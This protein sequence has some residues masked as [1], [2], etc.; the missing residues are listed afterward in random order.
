MKKL[1]NFFKHEAYSY[2]TRIKKGMY[3]MLK[4]ILRVLK[5]CIE[6]KGIG[7]DL[8]I[9]TYASLS[10]G[11][12]YANFNKR[13]EFKQLEEEISY[14]K[15]KQNT[16]KA[17]KLENK[18]IAMRKKE[19]DKIVLSIVKTKPKYITIETLGFNHIGGT[20]KEQCLKLH[21]DYFKM[22]MIKECSNYNIEL[23]I[24]KRFYKSSRICSKCGNVK[25]DLKLSDRTYFCKRCK[26]RID[27]DL[28]ASIN[29]RDCKDYTVLVNRR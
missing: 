17:N 27:R 6:P 16:T 24:C 9:K 26:L 7:I 10:N 5:R 15:G 29:I 13:P 21:S 12:T 3:Y 19:I 18:L 8:G 22:K 20:L 25:E 11:K 2:S 4:S 1:F 14:F 23:R 28:N